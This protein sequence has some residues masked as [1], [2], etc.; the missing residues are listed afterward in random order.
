MLKPTMTRTPSAT[1][2][3]KAMSVYK[4]EDWNA[5]VV[6]V[7]GTASAAD[8]IV[9]LNSAPRDASSVVVSLLHHFSLL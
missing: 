7:R 4:L 5:L 1:G 3:T 9:N 8:H 2:T 6:A